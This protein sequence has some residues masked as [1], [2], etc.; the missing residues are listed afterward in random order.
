[1]SGIRTKANEIM[2][3]TSQCD[4]DL[5]LIVETWL[6]SDFYDAEFFDMNLFNVYRKDRNA[7]R[8]GL[9]R[10]GGVLIAVKSKYKSYLCKIDD[11]DGLLDQIALYVI[12]FNQKLLISLSY[13]PPGSHDNIYSKHVSNIVNLEENMCSDT[14]LCVMG[15][16]NLSSICWT[17]MNDNY[18]LTPSNV[19][20]GFEV[21]FI[22]ALLSVG[23]VQ[24][25][26][27]ANKMR[28]FLDLIFVSRD[29][30]FKIYEC[31]IPVSPPSV[32]HV[33]TIIEME[34]FMY[35]PNDTSECFNFNYNACNFD[36]LNS[37]LSSINW[38]S[39]FPTCEPS[40]C[41]DIFLAKVLDILKL[42]VP[43]KK[44]KP[45]KLPWY[46]KGLKK[47]KNLRN[48]FHNRFIKSGNLEEQVK[49]LH[50]QKEFNFL[51]KF[52]YKQYI[53]SKENE[54][55][56]NVKHFW[57]FV[58]SKKK[59]SDIPSTVQYNSCIS[60]S[61]HDVVNM[62]ANF[63]QSNF[64]QPSTCNMTLPCSYS[65][66]NLGSIY[67]CE[68]DVFEAIG[69]IKNSYKSDADGLCAYF[70]K[71]CCFSIVSV[72][73]FIFRLSL[74][75]G[76]FIAKWKIASITPVFKEGRKDD[77]TCYRPISKLSCVS[78]IFENI[79][80]K[81][82]FFLCKSTISPYQH[83]FFSGRS[84][85]SNLTLFTDYCMT[86]LE[87][88]KQVEVIYTDLSKAFD[89][90]SHSILL[91]KLQN[92]GL[93]SN[94]L[95]W[96]HSYLTNRVCKVKVEGYVSQPYFQTSGV[97]QGSI[98][99]P[100]L[101]NLF[102]N[103]ISSCFSHSNFLLY[104]DDLK[105]FTKIESLQDINDLQVDLDNLV[106]WCN[107]NKLFLNLSKCF[108]VSYFRSLNP[109][110]PTF[111]IG[112][113]NLTKLT[114]IRDLGIIFDTSLSFIPHIDHII[115][116]A[117]KVFA[118]IKRN[119]AEFSDP[120][121][122]K[123]IYTAFVRSKLEYASIVWDPQ[124]SA[125]IV[126]IER[127]QKNFTKFALKNLFPAQMPPYRSRFLLLGLQ[128]L[129]SR[130][131]Y[132][133]ACFI[134]DL[135]NNNIDSPDLLSLVPTFV[136]PRSLRVVNLFDIPFHRTNYAR[137]GPLTR[138][139]LNLNFINNRLQRES[140]PCID[141]STSKEIFRSILYYIFL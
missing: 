115:P 130:R 19:N 97:P 73:T 66:I 33:P 118:F 61:G 104:A 31:L 138:T 80:F 90:V 22:D 96:I 105:F 49:F 29:C 114:S 110:Q 24:I 4:F 123:L 58:K 13:I 72:L 95:K 2:N 84:T 131:K 113:H 23:L 126:R 44:K 35:I 133:S 122:A 134:F 43:L 81:K 135:L 94:F 75:K 140:K 136:P 20:K 30:N 102:I 25:N 3:F 100:L 21:N 39:M 92:L 88:G 59:S 107:I 10:G 103:D 85:T 78:K 26:H 53:L 34:C 116:E 9:S 5:I 137:N 132:Q 50:Y 69:A 37:M 27:I 65:A 109:I 98:L 14:N 125:H 32:H 139:F 16:F 52:L 60:Q 51:N 38:V 46:T 8:T 129:E 141:F 47:L 67:I 120:N 86:A 70:L 82:L 36:V 6:N 45:Y 18:F 83:G 68:D 62:F 56:V 89:K 1:M 7:Y 17:M 101:F 54:I 117:Y 108:H 93:H 64:E 112:S 15:D 91:A 106:M 57:S 41:Y 40:N 119:C 12:G 121:T 87:R 74:K 128:S 71:S 79:I 76:I 28:R 42:N 77:V 48:K 127:I 63:F 11:D 124:C 111:K 55:K 99:G